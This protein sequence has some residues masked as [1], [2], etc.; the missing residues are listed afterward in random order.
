M[1]I[2][3]AMNEISVDKA[4]SRMARICSGRE[5]CRLDIRKKLDRYNLDHF[6]IDEIIS[7]L[8]KDNFLD[9]NR[10]VRS[11]INDKT[12][13]GKWGRKKIEF[14]LKQKN[15]PKEIIYEMFEEIPQPS[16]EEFLMPLLKKKYKSVKG[17]TEYD[18]RGKLIRFALGRGF[19]MDETIK[20]VE[21]IFDKNNMDELY[22]S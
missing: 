12:N 14:A 17:N 22:N 4:Y 21:K 3:T 2:T 15:I 20:C 11:F 8:E 7:R 5:Y 10:F 6:Q 18:K 1:L 19:S 9:E 16:M 13:F